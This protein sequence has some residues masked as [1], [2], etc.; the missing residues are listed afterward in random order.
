MLKFDH[1]YEHKYHHI[2][3]INMLVHLMDNVLVI[4]F[5]LSI[6]HMVGTVQNINYNNCFIKSG[7]NNIEKCKSFYGNTANNKR[8]TKFIRLLNNIIDFCI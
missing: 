2:L 1:N 6:R 4:N 8:N 7:S 3:I 5:S